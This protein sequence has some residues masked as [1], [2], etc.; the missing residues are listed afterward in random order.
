MNTKERNHDWIARPARSNVVMRTAKPA[1]ERAEEERRR[2]E[3]EAAAVRAEVDVAQP[4][5]EQ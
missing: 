2:G 5:E 3:S 1:D 4:G